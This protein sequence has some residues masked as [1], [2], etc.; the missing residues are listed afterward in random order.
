MVYPKENRPY[1]LD[2]VLQSYFKNRLGRGHR[3]IT[4]SLHYE[5]H[6]D[7]NKEESITHR[8]F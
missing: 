7:H 4:S 8:P 1:W 5:R 3:G 6:S 2:Q